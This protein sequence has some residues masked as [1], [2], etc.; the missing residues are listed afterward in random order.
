M[1]VEEI[2]NR[3]AVSVAPDTSIREAFDLV[4]KAKVHHI[5]VTENGKLVGLTTA[6]HL[7]QQ[8]H[9]PNDPS[10]GLE[11]TKTV[12][13]I[14]KTQVSTAHPLDFIEDIALVMYQQHI[15]CLPVVQQGQFVGLVTERDIMRTLIEMTGIAHPS[16]QI[17]IEIEDRVGNLADIVQVLK[18]HQLNI[19][20]AFFYPSTNPDKKI[21]VLRIETIDPRLVI[22][23]IKNAGHH[24]LWPQNLGDFE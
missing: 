9:S 12:A 7:R 10:E 15:G 8:C 16:S 19:S 23:K 11:P 20:S 13:T 18:D 1:R 2:M 17:E 22:E 4:R 21:L 14:M 3:N 24:I 6:R 5:P